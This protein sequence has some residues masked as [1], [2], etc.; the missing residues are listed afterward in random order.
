MVELQEYFSS[1]ESLKEFESKL[2][3]SGF[4][5]KQGCEIYNFF[6]AKNIDIDVQ[7]NN[8]KGKNIVEAPHDYCFVLELYKPFESFK[9][10][11]P[12]FKFFKSLEQ[13]RA[14][15]MYGFEPKHGIQEYLR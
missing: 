7:E 12:L 14:H 1:N 8:F 2:I 5:K 4:K 11:D 10:N 3:S 13:P 6:T 15:G 9:K